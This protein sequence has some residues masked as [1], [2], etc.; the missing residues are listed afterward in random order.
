MRRQALT[1]GSG[2]WFDLDRAEC[3]DEDTW[4]NGQHRVSRATGSEWD[5]E[6]LYRTAGGRWVRHRWSAWVGVPDRWEELTSAEAAQWLVTNGHEPHPACAS[7]YA[8]LE[9][10]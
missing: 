6:R 4:W 10:P 2:R 5:H 3:W 7:E 9:V 1:D 8:A